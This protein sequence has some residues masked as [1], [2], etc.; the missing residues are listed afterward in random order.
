[1]LGKREKKDT[2]ALSVSSKV[3]LA[4]GNYTVLWTHSLGNLSEKS[5][6]ADHILIFVPL[7]VINKYWHWGWSQIGLIAFNLFF[8]PYLTN[9]NKRTGTNNDQNKMER[10]KTNG[11]KLPTQD[12][13]LHDW[14]I[15]IRQLTGLIDKLLPYTASLRSQNLLF[16]IFLERIF[17]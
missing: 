6:K 1:M 3:P 9:N 4:C 16:Q 14:K 7:K 2:D 12:R 8:H 11:K 15:A 10:T 17:F 13:Q 5:Y